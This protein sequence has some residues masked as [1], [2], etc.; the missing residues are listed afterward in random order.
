MAAF[1]HSDCCFVRSV[2]EIRSSDL[3]HREPQFTKFEAEYG[4]FDSILAHFPFVC[5]AFHSEE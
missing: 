5:V 4:P 3:S 1:L 2:S